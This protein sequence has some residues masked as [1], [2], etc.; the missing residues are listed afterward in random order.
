MSE[1]PKLEWMYKTGK[2]LINHEEYLTGRK[3]DK[4]FEELNSGQGDLNCVEHEVLPASIS[5]K[6]DAFEDRD[7]VDILRKQMEDPLMAIKQKE[8][9]ARRKILEN[10]VR[11]KEMYRLLKQEKVLRS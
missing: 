11:L 8:M 5:R 1:K 9:D 6:K 4:Q 7:Q 2:D 3:V 10:P